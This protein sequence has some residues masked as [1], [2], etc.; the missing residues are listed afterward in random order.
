[1]SLQIT[2][3]DAV[4]FSIKGSVGELDMSESQN[5]KGHYFGSSTMLVVSHCQDFFFLFFLLLV[6]NM[7]DSDL[8]IC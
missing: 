8:G 1:M 2:M 3:K 7:Y 4:G 6:A 5:Q